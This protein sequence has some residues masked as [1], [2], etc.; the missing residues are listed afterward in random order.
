MTKL[1]I[2]VVSYNTRTELEAC[3]RSIHE[4]RPT[5][6]HDVVVVDNASLDGS[7]DAVRSTWPNVRL[8]EPGENL[9]YARANNRGIRATA[10]EL[11]LLLN[12]DTVVPPGAI[13]ALVRE[14]DAHPRVSVVGPRLV[15]GEG[16]PELSVGSMISPFN[17]ARQKL[18]GFMLDRRIPLL[19]RW[20][21]RTLSRRHYPDWVSGA[22]LLARRADAAGLLDERFFLYGEDVDFCAAVRRRGGR[23]LF[24]PEIEVVHHRGR[25]GRTAPAR[26][27]AAYRRS[28]LAFYAKHHPIWT[29]GLQL[30]LW[31][32]GQLPEDRLEDPPADRRG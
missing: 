22:C 3:L 12:S 21:A 11:I 30:Y 7:A 31:V 9:G 26:R 24:V 25:S 23:I 14:L 28:Q 15:D 17:E 6:S 20:V 19:S 29:P 1:A 10:S 5:M 16:H 4:P 8:I 2:I 18:R 27:Q 13:D 32:K